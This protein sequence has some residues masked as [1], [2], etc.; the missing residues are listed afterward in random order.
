[1]IIE[2]IPTPLKGSF[3]TACP[4]C[5]YKGLYEEYHDLVVCFYCDYRNGSI[6]ALL[7]FLGTQNMSFNPSAQRARK[8]QRD[9]RRQDEGEHRSLQGPPAQGF[10]RRAI[11]PDRDRH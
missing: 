3:V 5:G 2:N 9:V 7:E 10:L 6:S 11:H 1:M 4:H 8:R